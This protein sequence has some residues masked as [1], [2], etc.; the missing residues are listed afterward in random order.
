MTKRVFVEVPDNFF[1][2]DKIELTELMSDVYDLDEGVGFEVDE[3]WGCEEGTHSFVASCVGEGDAEP[4]PD[5]RLNDDGTVELVEV[6]DDEE[7]L[8]DIRE[9]LWPLGDKDHSWNADTIDEVARALIAAGYGPTV[10]LPPCADDCGSPGTSEQR[11]CDA[12]DMK[13]EE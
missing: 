6:L 2:R 13:E 8:M 7:L 10:P 4:S 5:Y 12:C 1:K 3:E 9:I 11:G